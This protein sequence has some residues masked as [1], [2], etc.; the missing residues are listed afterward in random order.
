LGILVK[1]D[2]TRHGWFEFTTGSATVSRARLRLYQARVAADANTQYVDV[3][4]ARY[5]FDELL[6]SWSNQP[7]TSSWTLLGTWDVSNTVAAW[8]ALD[9]TAFYNAN[10]D[11]TL[12]F[13]VSSR[14]QDNTK[15]GVY[16]ED[17]ENSQGSGF[18]PRISCTLP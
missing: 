7:N 3:R 1:H 2:V 10:L 6:L 8:Y 9:I 15:V 5:G 17:R 12:T 4:A 13:Q 14:R 18:P 11:R 16:F